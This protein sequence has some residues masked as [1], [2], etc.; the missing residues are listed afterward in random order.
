MIDKHMD[1]E[2]WSSCI[3]E[4]LTWFSYS[5]NTIE[6]WI[7]HVDAVCVKYVLMVIVIMK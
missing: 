4:R 5:S 7:V 3:N 6:N 1:Y 2:M